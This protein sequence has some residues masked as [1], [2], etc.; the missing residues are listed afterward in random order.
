[1]PAAGFGAPDPAQRARIPFLWGAA[2]SA[3]QIE[4][5]VANDWTEWERAG[6]LKPGAAGCGEGSGH[7]RRWESDFELLIGIGANAYRYSVEWSRIEPSPGEFDPVE[8]ELERRR[9]ARLR[10]LGI[11]PVVTLLH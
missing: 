2:T 4:G 5:A 1:M 8:L 11:E 10:R 6:R 7:R 9:V 3:Y